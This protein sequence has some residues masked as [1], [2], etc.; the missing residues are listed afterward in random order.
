MCYMLHFLTSL[1]GVTFF[2]FIDEK[3]K[4]P[5]GEMTCLGK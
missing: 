3:N 4:V 2:Q 5:R 1:V